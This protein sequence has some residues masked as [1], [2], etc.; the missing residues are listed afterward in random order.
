VFAAVIPNRQAI[1]N[2]IM[3]IVAGNQMTKLKSIRGLRKPPTP[4]TQFTPQIANN[5]L[6]KY[7]S[8]TY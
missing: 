4:L 7:P 5:T 1:R 8:R 3:M 2:M 6:I